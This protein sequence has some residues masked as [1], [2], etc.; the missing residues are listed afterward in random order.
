MDRT[1]AVTQL[2]QQ[3][4]QELDAVC[5]NHEVLLATR[6]HGENVVLMPESDYLSLYETAYL[7]GSSQN[8]ER[9]SLAIKSKGHVYASL[10]ELEKDLGI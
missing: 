2:R 1:I 10:A 6:A 8:R 7:L 4:K 5:N 3:M 9:L